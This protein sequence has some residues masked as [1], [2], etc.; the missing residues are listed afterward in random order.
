MRRGARL[1]WNLAGWLALALGVIGL[2]LPVVPTT[3]FIILAAFAFGRGSPEMRRRL[4]NS[5][6]FGRAIRDW[7]AHGAIRPRHKALACLLMAASLLGGWVLGLAPWVLL[8]QATAMAA[9][10]AFVLTRPS[11]GS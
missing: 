6:H 1:A 11:T 9:A 10:A 3:P 7:E 4:E 5:R 2:L 8:I